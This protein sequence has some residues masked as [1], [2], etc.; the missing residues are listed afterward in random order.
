[1]VACAATSH[2]TAVKSITIWDLF[3]FVAS[4]HGLSCRSLV[5]PECSNKRAP[6]AADHTS[7]IVWANSGGVCMWFCL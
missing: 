1:M 5:T 3:A 2:R 6:G 7:L 4:G